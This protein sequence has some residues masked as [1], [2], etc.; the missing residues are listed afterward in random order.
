[1]VFTK[2]EKELANLMIN[3]ITVGIDNTDKKASIIGEIGTSKNYMSE[4]EKK[5]FVAS[6][7]LQKC[8]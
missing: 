1:M 3:E 8:T 4:L 6:Y 2:N 7:R 5:V